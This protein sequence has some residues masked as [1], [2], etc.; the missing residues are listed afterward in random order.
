MIRNLTYDLFSRIIT[1]RAREPLV[2]STGFLKKKLLDIATKEGGPNK[3]ASIIVQQV[4][5]GDT[6]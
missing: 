2:P 3:A 6:H 1:C 5:H 4:H